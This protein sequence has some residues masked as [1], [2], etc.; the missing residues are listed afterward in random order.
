MQRVSEWEHQ[1]IGFP[2]KNTAVR[3]YKECS[4]LSQNTKATEGTRYK[5]NHHNETWD[6]HRWHSRKELIPG[7]T[8]VKVWLASGQKIPLWQTVR[9]EKLLSH[10]PS[11][12]MAMPST[13]C[14]YP[15]LGLCKGDTT[16]EWLGNLPHQGEE[17]LTGRQGIHCMGI[18]FYLTCLSLT[19]FLFLPLSFLFLSLS[20]SHFMLNKICT[21]WLQHM[22]SFAP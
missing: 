9:K 19:S 14:G 21:I 6:K 4:C 7:L 12:V 11:Q 5:I 10:M 1:K 17:G 20:T 2:R 18:S 13:P 16:K 3:T 15:E 8:E 22:V